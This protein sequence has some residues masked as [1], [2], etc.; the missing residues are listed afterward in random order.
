VIALGID[1]FLAFGV[2]IILGMVLGLNTS[3]HLVFVIPAFFILL[4]FCIGTGLIV[5]ISTVYFRD[6]QYILVLGMQGLFFLTPVIYPPNAITGS[7]GQ[8]LLLNPLVPIIEMFRAPIVD[9]AMP[10]VGVFIYSISVAL[11]SL[12]I[13]LLMYQRNEKNIV[14][15]L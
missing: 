12:I 6:L 13:G 5:S 9:Q 4:V 7:L 15:R 11:A 8:L 3:W 14:F 10:G 2:F 1:S